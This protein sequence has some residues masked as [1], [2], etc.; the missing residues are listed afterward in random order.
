MDGISRSGDRRRE[1]CIPLL[2]PTC[3]VDMDLPNVDGTKCTASNVLTYIV[4]LLSV[5][6]MLVEHLHASASTPK[7]GDLKDGNVIHFLRDLL[8]LSPST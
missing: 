4:R 6:M 1:V 2:I 8:G 5:A 3:G 7:P